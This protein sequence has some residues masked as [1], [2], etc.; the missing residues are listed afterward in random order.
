MPAL[1]HILSPM[2]AAWCGWVMLFLLLCAILS[3]VA[4]PGVITQVPVSLFSRADRTYKSVPDNFLGQLLITLFRI[5][6][7]SMAITLCSDAGQPFYFTKFLYAIGIVL[8]VIGIKMLCNAWLNFT[9]RLTRSVDT[10]FDQY[11]N[12]TTLLAV[13]LY[14]CMLVLMRI[15]NTV[16]V[17]AVTLALVVLFLALWLYRF[18]R[19]FVTSPKAIGYVAIYFVT[20]EV[21]P[22]GLLTLFT[23]QILSVI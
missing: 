22:I 17:R 4:Q 18:G 8:A 9:F 14:P 3:E 5:G 23:L 12:L 16:A 10:A 1:P 6:T 20:L 13:L 21:L 11:G 19:L 15:G 2:N 7:I